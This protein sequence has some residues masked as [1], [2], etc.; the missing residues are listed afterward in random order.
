MPCDGWTTGTVVEVI[1]RAK[2]CAVVRNL[3]AAAE[4]DLLLRTD[5]NLLSVRARRKR[6][7]LAHLDHGRITALVDL[8]AVLA[9]LLQ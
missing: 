1:G 2:P 8:R 7:A 3:V 4:R 9:R 5:G 6:G